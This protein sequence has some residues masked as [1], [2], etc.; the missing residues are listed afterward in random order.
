MIV[1][2]NLVKRFGGFRAVDGASLHI[3]KGSIT[4]LIGPNG[5]G[6]TTLFNVVAGRYQPTSGRV[7]MDGKDITGLPPH[8]LFLHR[9]VDGADPLPLR[10]H[11]FHGGVHPILAHHRGHFGQPLAHVPLILRPLHADNQHA[12]RRRQR[13]DAERGRQP[14]HGQVLGDADRRRHHPLRFALGAKGAQ[15]R[16]LPLLMRQ[17]NGW[18]APGAP[19]D[20]LRAAELRERGR[21]GVDRRD[22]ILRLGDAHA[23]HAA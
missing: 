15:H 3:K 5:A 17:V 12:L 4:G 10:E 21:G 11:Q 9:K 1:V 18:L 8:V 14:Q 7:L 6:K 23:R 22:Q 16:Q 19:H 2:E 13:A 20:E